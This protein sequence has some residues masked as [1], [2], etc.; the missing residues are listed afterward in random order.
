MFRK[1]FSTKILLG[2]IMA[3]TLLSGLYLAWNDSLT[4]DE[5]IH[6]ASAYL[7][8]ERGSYR[9]DPEHPYL[10]KY[11]TALPLFTLKLNYP[12][13]DNQ[14]WDKSANTYYDSWYEARLWADEWF[15]KSGNPTNIM[16]F[17]ARIPAV[18]IATL[19]I[20]V[21]FMFAR[22]L[23]TPR[24]GVASAALLALSPTFLGHN[25]LTN[26]DVP[27]AFMLTLT[28]WALW[29]YFLRPNWKTAALSG[30]AFS[31][32]LNTKHSAVSFIVVVFALMLFTKL[33]T[34]SLKWKEVIWH[35]ILILIICWAVIWICYGFHSTIITNSNELQAPLQK[36]NN[37]LSGKHSNVESMANILKY[38]L[39]IDYIKGVLLIIGGAAMG[40]SSYL[41]EHTVY[42][43][44]WYYF[45]VVFLLKTQIIALIGVLVGL[46]FIAK[47]KFRSILKPEY[48][49][50]FAPL[51]IYGII[52]ITNKLNLG[53]RHIMPMIPLLS[54]VLAVVVYK[55]RE[56]IQDK[57]KELF[58]G[59]CLLLYLLPVMLQFPN[60]L[61]FSNLFVEPYQNGYKYYN[62]SNLDWGQQAKY[63]TRYIKEKYPNE[64]IYSNY[65]WNPYA[66]EQNG[67]AVKPYNA[68]NPPKN[69]LIVLTAT[70]LTYDE[71]R[72]FRAAT[73]V[74]HL[75]NH[76]IFYRL[77]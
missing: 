73:P 24:V 59:A 41:F 19:F 6:T 58:T 56:K 17:L 22:Q 34:A 14:L 42:G 63:L 15:Y 8:I 60:M 5:G 66:L 48:F 37:F 46:Y 32:A 65:N 30:L 11:L 23:F 9:F 49:F 35:F 44:I 38:I 57:Y 64:E 12:P 53:I 69:V 76:S 52:S 68:Q 29:N 28:V 62:D 45:P 2:L 54:I 61:G 39:P 47:N 26:T 77:Q 10:Y 70:Q 55:I 51:I 72:I 40:R 16:V 7:A 74:D 20:L 25:H 43:G 21:I 4:T 71:Y 3:W 67:L 1:L 33:K 18:I 50:L 13:S 27:V 75:A 31:L 36:I